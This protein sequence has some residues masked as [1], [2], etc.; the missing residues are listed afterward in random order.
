ML[1][2]HT[3]G[4]FRVFRKHNMCGKRQKRAAKNKR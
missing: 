3:K 2:K 4:H 1:A